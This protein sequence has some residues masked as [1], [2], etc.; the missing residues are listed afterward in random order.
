MPSVLSVFHIKLGADIYM[1]F[2]SADEYM[3]AAR[4]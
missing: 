4:W 3:K 2:S 1:I